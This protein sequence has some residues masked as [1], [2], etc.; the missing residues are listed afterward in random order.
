MGVP[1][2]VSGR[3]DI[4]INEKK[5]SVNAQRLYKNKILHHGTLLFNSNL[6]V[7]GKSLKVGI[8]K[9][10]S[11][12]IKSIRSRVT[13]ISD[14]LSEKID[15]CTFRKVLL[16]YLFKGE[17]PDEYQLSSKDLS[18]VNRLVKEKYATWDWNYGHSP[19]YSLV[20]S[21]RF[22]GGKI[23][24]YLDIQNG[25]IRNNK[26]YGDFLSLNDVSDVESLFWIS[27]FEPAL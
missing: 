6:D 19:D 5:I 26:I 15:I 25:I 2:Q 4:T 18:E 14:Y 27:R 21:K 24:C 9:I 1:A 17:V 20:N 13:N 8:D 10:R 3:N 11:K 22:S 7:L 12:G 23:E 16:K